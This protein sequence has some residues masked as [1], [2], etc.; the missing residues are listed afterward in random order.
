MNMSILEGKSITANQ[1]IESSEAV[2]FLN[3]KRLIIV[4]NS[5]LFT[6][7]RKGDAELIYDFINNIPSF[8]CLV[9]VEGKVD[10]KNKLYKKMNKMKW[11]VQFEFPKENDLLI[12]IKREFKRNHKEIDGKTSVYLLRVIGRSMRDL[13]NEINKLISYTEEKNIISIEDIDKICTKSL[14]SHVFDLLKAMG[15]KKTDKVLDIY[16]N[17]I[18]NKEPPA[19]ILTMITRQ[20]RLILEVKYLSQQGFNGRTIAKSIKEPFFVVNDCLKQS[21]LFTT[22]KLKQGLKHCLE[23]D[24]A[25]KTG[26]MDSQLA[27]EIFLVEFSKQ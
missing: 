23:T 24:I 14:E 4:K 27:V 11:V 8:T 12:W 10:K 13:Q 16:S 17:L 2:P 22:E 7:K 9:F 1:I 20:I 6:S 26:K 25:S 3:D 15:Y 19:K 18:T 21:E 5:E